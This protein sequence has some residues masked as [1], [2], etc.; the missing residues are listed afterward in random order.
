MSTILINKGHF[1][2]IH[3]AHSIEQAVLVLHFDRPLEPAYLAT[4]IE[5]ANRFKPELPGS[6]QIQGGF[7]VAFGGPAMP[8][9]ILPQAMPMT[10]IVLYRSAPD[11]SIESELRVEQASITFRTTRYTRWS[12]I[13]EQAS[14]YYSAVIGT[15]FENGLA[16]VNTSINFVDKFF[17]NGEIQDFDPSLLLCKDSNDHGGC[18]HP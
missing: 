6:G 12:A 18:R 17:W 8:M 9:P 13:W 16:L 14:K 4:V 10:G 2:P 15:Y 7:S 1:E 5:I 11:G 3:S